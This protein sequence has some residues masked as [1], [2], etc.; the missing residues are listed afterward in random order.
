MVDRGV[1]GATARTL[2]QLRGLEV[3]AGSG[4]TTAGAPPHPARLAI[5][6]RAW[7]PRSFSPSDTIT[8]ATGWLRV[9][10]T[11]TTLPFDEL[12][13]Y[14]NRGPALPAWRRCGRL[15]TTEVEQAQI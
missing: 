11:A 13:A 6:G 14:V 1:T 9:A 4:G 5:G 7:P 10:C 3:R 15:S 12:V 8:S 2:G